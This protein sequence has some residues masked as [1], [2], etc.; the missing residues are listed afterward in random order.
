MKEKIKKLK[1]VL[2]NFFKRYRD[3]GGEEDI[4]WDKVEILN[5]QI[6]EIFKEELK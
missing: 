4:K 3:S 5:K 2:E 6:D 1:A